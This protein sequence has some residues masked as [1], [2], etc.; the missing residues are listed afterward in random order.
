[1]KRATLFLLA[2]LLAATAATSARAQIKYVAVVETEIDEQSG[3]SARLNKAE[4]RQIT[5]ALRDVAVKNL[6]REKYNIMTSETVMAQGG[7][8]LEEC[9]EE[10][11]VIALGAKIGADYI[12]RG[13]V[14]KFGTHLTMSVE[15]YE[16]EDG[17]LVGTSGLVRSENVIELLDKATGVCADMYKTFVS[18]QGSLRK[19]PVTPA[20]PAEPAEPMEP[21]TE[22]VAAEALPPEV[23]A[24]LHSLEYKPKPEPAAPKPNAGRAQATPIKRRTL[25]AASLDIVGAGVLLYGLNK[26]SNV[27][28]NI[29]EMMWSAAEESAKQRGIAYIVGSIILLSG[30][31]VHIFF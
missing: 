29:D 4:V 8:K 19:T 20:E 11:C 27:K 18:T 17:N 31:S 28:D 14:S 25:I 13:L 16:T 21:A 23:G 22:T 24:A 3:A 26:D 5:T 2:A 1:M 7:A 6:P 9:A 15:M 10:N 30:I 12:V